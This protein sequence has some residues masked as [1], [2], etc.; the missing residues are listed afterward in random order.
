MKELFESLP[1][2]T[3]DDNIDFLIDTCFFVWIFKHHKEKDFKEFLKNNKCAIT[4]FNV[5]EF[6]HI[7]H[8]IHD[9][10][11]VCVRKFLHKAENL[12]VLEVPVHPGNAEK[13]HSFVKSILPELDT[14]EHDP[15]DAVIL[16]AAIKTK[17]NVLT[18]DKHDIFNVR[19]ENFLRKYNIKVLNSFYRS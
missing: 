1:K 14:E 3:L 16:A 13:E 17:A 15:S 18:R 8:H 10:V 4:S 6:V 2:L 7:E 19:M 9:K 12:F 5:E 11:K